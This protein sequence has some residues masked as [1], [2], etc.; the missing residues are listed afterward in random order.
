MPWL[1]GRIKTFKPDR[2]LLTGHNFGS[3]VAA[4]LSG[5]K[6]FLSVHFH[7]GGRSVWL[8]RSYY[9]L[10][11]RVCSGIRFI[12]NYIFE[13][14]EDLLRG[15]AHAV[16]FPNIFREPKAV[17]ECRAARGKL[18]LPEDAF[19]VGNAGWL[20]HRKAF[21]VLIEVAGLVV[22]QEPKALFLIAG[23]GDQRP[24]LEKQARDL[25][26][27]ENIRFIGWQKD[28]SSFYAALDVLLFNT[29]F[30]AVGRTPLEALMYGVPIVASVSKGGLDEFIRHGQD[31]FLIG[32][33][34]TEA[35]AD[36]VL[37][38]GRDPAG[39]KDLAQARRARVLESGSPVSHAERLVKFLDL[40]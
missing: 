34:D 2:I 9:A 35:L 28:L 29:R 3:L 26:L 17:G 33:H 22:R 1:L 25:G 13:E 4:G 24:A 27:S 36:E 39:K 16:C 5:R 12:C 30:D 38:L 10:A 23:D 40:T 18:G 14:V 11:T 8:W 15:Y 6:T 31:G 20:V 19:I 32:S 21:D 7:H 37:R